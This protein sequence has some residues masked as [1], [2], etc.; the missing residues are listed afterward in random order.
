M[1]GMKPMSLLVALP[2]VLAGCRD[3]PTEPVQ[4]LNEEEAEALLLGLMEVAADTTALVSAT[5]DGGVYACARGGQLMATIDVGQERVGDTVRVNTDLSLDPEGC[6]FWS[7]GYQFTLDGNPGVR[8]EMT[9][10][11]VNLSESFG[12]EMAITGA[13]DWQLDDRSGTCMV[14]LEGG[15]EV[16]LSN[17]ESSEG[18]IA[19]ALCG[20]EVDIDPP[21]TP[22]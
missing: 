7:D 5:D 18:G 11:A 19:G 15:G 3:S 20:L 22:V 16:D 13:V 12:L 9:L 8:I 4:P 21:V 10:S 1:P 14:D 17:P 6:V 2:I